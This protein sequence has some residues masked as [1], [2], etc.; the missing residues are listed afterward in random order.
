M[1]IL[2]E[3]DNSR[4]ILS[5]TTDDL[6]YREMELLG[7]NGALAYLSCVRGQSLLNESVFILQ[8]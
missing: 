6:V 8:R 3:V 7:I 2:F 4:K 1:E 5:V